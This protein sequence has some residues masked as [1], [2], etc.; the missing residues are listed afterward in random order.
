MADHKEE[1]SPDIISPVGTLL[2]VVATRQQLAEMCRER[3]VQ[4]HGSKSDLT[5][6]I[7][8]VYSPKELWFTTGIP[9]LPK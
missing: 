7:L 9:S 5:S 4:R 1:Q 3:G 8:K 2:G 6:R